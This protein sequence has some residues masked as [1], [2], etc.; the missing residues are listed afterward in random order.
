MRSRL[1]AR[2]CGQRDPAFLDGREATIR[3]FFVGRR[4]LGETWRLT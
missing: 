4:A 3:D 2:A 1:P